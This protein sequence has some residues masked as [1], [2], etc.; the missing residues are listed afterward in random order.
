MDVWQTQ[1]EV[2]AALHELRGE[3]VA[4]SDGRCWYHAG[5]RFW[6]P[7]DFLRAGP[8]ASPPRAPRLGY[9]Q[10]VAEDVGHHAMLPV[11]VVEGLSSYDGSAMPKKRRHGWGGSGRWAT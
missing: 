11:K 10:A 7:V 6:R 4:V 8:P 2:A 1:V 9:H 3:T 5:E